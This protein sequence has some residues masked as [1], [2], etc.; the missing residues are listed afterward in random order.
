MHDLHVFLRLMHACAAIFCASNVTRCRA[1]IAVHSS[2]P[3][4]G[5]KVVKSTPGRA[6]QEGD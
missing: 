6:R 5:M 3:F 4:F 2:S 1:R